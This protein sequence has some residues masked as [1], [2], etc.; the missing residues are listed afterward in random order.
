[1]NNDTRRATYLRDRVELT[2]A[3]ERRLRHKG[4]QALSDRVAKFGH[5]RDARLRKRFD[6]LDRRRVRAEATRFVEH[7]R[8]S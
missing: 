6:R 8:R 4:N 7:F 3:Q 5:G 2:P 1:M